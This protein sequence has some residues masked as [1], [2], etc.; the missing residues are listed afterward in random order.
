MTSNDRPEKAASKTEAT[1]TEAR[2][3]M[4]EGET[5]KEAFI[6][7]KEEYFRDLERASTVTEEATKLDQGEQMKQLL[8]CPSPSHVPLCDDEGVW[9]QIKREGVGEKA[10]KGKKATIHYTAR[11]A[12]SGREIENSRAGGEGPTEFEVGDSP[13]VRKG[14]HLIVERMSEG[15]KASAIVHYSYAY[16]KEG[17]F[18]F[19]MVPQRAT[20]EYD[21]ELVSVDP[22]IPEPPI[23]EMSTS[24]MIASAIRE[25]E[26]GN[27]AFRSGLVE[28]AQVKYQKALSYVQ[29]KADEQKQEYNN[30]KVSVL[31]NLTMVLIKLEDF[32]QACAMATLVEASFLFC[33]SFL[34]FP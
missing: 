1:E 3:I 10:E 22:Y 26:L 28:K 16:G 30:V 9:M 23:F 11:I 7:K 34:T 18:S 29:F 33:P 31:A 6:R 15:E 12:D 19:P 27:I 20:I 17:Q 4:R 5:L 21:I 14:V 13:L 24:M 8:P 25:K 32:G 2:G